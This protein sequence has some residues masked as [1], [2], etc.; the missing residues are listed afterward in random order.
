MKFR[1]LRE[2]GAF[3]EGDVREAEEAE[4]AHLIPKCLELIGP[5]GS[6]EEELAAKAEPAPNNKAEPAA[7]A[8][9]AATGKKGKAK[10]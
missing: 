5:A 9:K 8:N 2:H 1:V 7:P 10:A 3:V 4:V 6:K